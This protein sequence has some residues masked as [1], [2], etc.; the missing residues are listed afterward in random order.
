MTKLY[1]GKKIVTAWPAIMCAADGH[2]TTD[3]EGYSLKYEDGYI[4][5]SPKDLFEATY[6]LI[7]GT[8]GFLAHHL[9]VAGD[10]AD[11]RNNFE[12]LSL[13]FGTELFGKLSEAERKLLEEQHVLQGQLLEVLEDRLNGFVAEALALGRRSADDG[14]AFGG[15][16]IQVGERL[17]DET[18]AQTV[19]RNALK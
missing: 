18:Y 2:G 19:A 4:S 17:G 11:L 14:F 12:K 7:E 6:V 16:R 8:Q 9:R 10:Y 1:I 5:W 3:Q 13:F 15:D